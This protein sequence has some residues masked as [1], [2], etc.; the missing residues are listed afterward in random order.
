MPVLS[1]RDL[2]HAYGDRSILDGVSLAITRGERVGLIGQ[3]GAGKSTLAAILCGAVEPDGG[4]VVL[5]GGCDLAYLAQEVDFGEHRTPRDYIRAGLAAWSEATARYEEATEALAGDPGDRGLLEAQARAADDIERHGGWDVMHRVDEIASHLGVADLDAPVADMSG[6]ERR[7]VD[8]ARVLLARPS[9][10]ILDEPTNHLDVATIEWLEGYLVADHP[11]AVLLI[12][13]D[14]A[15]LDRVAQRTLELDGGA[16]Y[17]YP[18]GWERYLEAKAERLAHQA[19]REANR[20]NQLRR[21]L[22]WLRRSPKART[23]KSQARVDRVEA[24]RDATPAQQQREASLEFVAARTGKTVV[25]LRDLRVSIAGRRL[26]DGLDLALARGDRVGIIGA[27]GAGKTSLLRVLL[28]QLE[29]E[30]GQVITGATARFAHFD[31][32]RAELDGE[33]TVAENVAANRDVVEVAGRE[34]KTVSYLARML[35]PADK[36]RQKVDTLSGGERARVAIAKFLL[37][38]ANVLLLDEPTN[39]LDVDTLAALEEMLIDSG[40][41]VLFVTHD[42]YFLDRVATAVLSFEG[43]GQVVRYADS[44]QAIAGLRAALRATG[45]EPG[46]AKPAPPPKPASPPTAGLTFSEEHELEQLMPLIDEAEAALAAI[47][48]EL[49]DPDLYASRGAEVPAL[50]ARRDAARAL[51]DQRVARWEELE[52]KR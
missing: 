37:T 20:Q 29:P 28:G 39:D 41:T 33:R 23:T 30:S 13:H 32:E 19:R 15:V 16:I 51:V 5:R 38:R 9:L 11:G 49:A 52:G 17:E 48:S 26:I 50:Q 45:P 36:Q 2:R 43:D 27:N 21:E 46:S 1:A 14:R 3:N 6:G 22:E 24:L 4:E 10:A 25:E 18:G 44:A 47:E 31:Q 8:L 7:R 34:I 40:A 12:T 42:R 35:F